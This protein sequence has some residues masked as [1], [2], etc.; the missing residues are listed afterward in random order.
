MQPFSLRVFDVE[1]LVTPTT[2]TNVEIT[3]FNPQL[4]LLMGVDDT[5]AYARNPDGFNTGETVMLHDLPVLTD[6]PGEVRAVLVHGVTD[7]PTINV[8]AANGDTLVLGLHYGAVSDP[9]SIAA[10]NH[11]VDLVRRSDKQKL[12]TYTFDVT[13]QANG[14]VAL[15]LSGFLDP[16]ANQN[17]PAMELGVYEIKMTPLTAVEERGDS[18]PVSFE[19]QQNYPNPFNPVTSIQFSVSSEQFVSLKVYDVLGKE[20]ATLVHEK[21]SVGVYRVSFNASKLVSGVYFVKMRA[22]DLSTGSGQ[23]FIATR[24][25]L[26][27]R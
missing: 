16:A 7:A 13:D 20:V 8:V 17:G 21:K 24:K 6:N 22:G 3:T 19:L 12:G 10:G 2:G 14:Y 9:I 18:A 15:A 11:T 23:K 5:T 4:L 25:I 27:M 1:N 26:L